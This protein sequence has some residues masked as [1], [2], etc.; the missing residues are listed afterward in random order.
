M[1]LATL[2]TPGTPLSS[3]TSSVV[4]VFRGSKELEYQCDVQSRGEVTGQSADDEVDVHRQ[5]AVSQRLASSVEDLRV[6]GAQLS[7]GGT[8]RS[9][10]VA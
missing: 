10:T 2:A 3:C 4:A 7:D 6:L 8:A 9:I 5:S 1:A